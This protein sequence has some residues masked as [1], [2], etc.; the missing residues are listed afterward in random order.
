MFAARQKAVFRRVDRRGVIQRPSEMT[1]RALPPD[2]SA[3]T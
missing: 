2:A 1:G 3:E